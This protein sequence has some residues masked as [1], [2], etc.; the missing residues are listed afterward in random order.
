MIFV[1]LMGVSL[2]TIT[3]ITYNTKVIDKHYN[4]Y[5]NQRQNTHTDSELDNY[6]Y[7]RVDNK[8]EV[9][10]EAKYLTDFIEQMKTSLSPAQKILLKCFISDYNFKK[11]LAILKKDNQHFKTSHYKTLL[12][13][14]RKYL[15]YLS[16]FQ[17]KSLDLRR[18]MINHSIFKNVSEDIKNAYRKNNIVKLIDS[19]KYDRSEELITLTICQLLLNRV[20]PDA[21]WKRLYAVLNI[22]VPDTRLKKSAEEQIIKK[23]KNPQLSAICYM[24]LAVAEMTPEL[25]RGF[26]L[27]NIVRAEKRCVYARKEHEKINFFLSE[28][29]KYDINSEFD[30]AINKIRTLINIYDTNFLMNAIRILYKKE[31]DFVFAL[32]KPLM[33]IH[34][35]LRVTIIT[36][37]GHHTSKRNIITIDNIDSFMNSNNTP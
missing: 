28:A 29:E 23:F 24:N 13:R 19:I 10:L 6:Y 31:P 27:T 33:L 7:C 32:M 35:D 36:N 8:T 4:N 34:K 3:G 37:T 16:A 14:H 5:I 11:Y 20:D 17:Y 18:I 12:E 1:L 22:N 25:Y 21:S 15:R 30:F 9:F 2:F 26:N